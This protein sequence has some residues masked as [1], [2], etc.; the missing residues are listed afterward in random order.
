MF[1]VNLYLYFYRNSSYWH[2]NSHTAVCFTSKLTPE[3]MSNLEMCTDISIHTQHNL[4]DP[5]VFWLLGFTSCI[6]HHQANYKGTR[7]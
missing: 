1:K 2:S 7:K 6:V 4:C 3:T 5:F